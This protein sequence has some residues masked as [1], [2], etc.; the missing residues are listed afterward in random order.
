MHGALQHCAVL[1]EARR[2]PRRLEFRQVSGLGVMIPAGAFLVIV[3]SASTP[4]SR[5]PGGLGSEGRPAKTPDKRHRPCSLPA[6]AT[7]EPLGE[8][9]VSLACRWNSREVCPSLFAI[10]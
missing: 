7:S 3:L 5:P 2:I 4:T 10:P 6:K 9:P 1:Q 8:Y